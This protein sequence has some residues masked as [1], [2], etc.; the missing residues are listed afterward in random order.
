MGWKKSVY[1]EKKTDFRLKTL[2]HRKVFRRDKNFCQSC[3]KQLPSREL[4]VHHIIPRSEGG[5]NL[6]SNL[7]TLCFSCHDLIEMADPPI[8]TKQEILW[9]KVSLDELNR[10]IQEVDED[11][12]D[13]KD[14]RR[15]VYGS[16]R[17]PRLSK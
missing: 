4:S 11:E 3:R 5:T 15:W 1:K 12:I 17:K 16:S 2:P 8:R 10:D 14:W 6:L 9:H 7:I 13:T